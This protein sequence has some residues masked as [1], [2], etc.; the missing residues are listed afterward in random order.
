MKVAVQGCLHGDLD[1]I[2]ASVAHLEQH[3]NVRVDLVISC[4]DFQAIRNAGDLS[5]IA[6]PD[7]YKELKGFHRYYSGEK[8]APYP[9]LFI[10]GN[11]EASNYL[12]ELYYGGWVAPNIYYL[13]CSGVVRFGGLRIAGL[14]GI[15]DSRSYRLG[16]FE[17]PPY[18]RGSLRTV[19]HVREYEVRKL[20]HLKERSV[21]VF[22]SHDWPRGVA[23]CG[24]CNRARL[25]RSKPYFRQEV[26]R[27]ELGS[28]AAA[29]L[30]NR[31]KPGHWFSAHFHVKFPAVIHH[32][33]SIAEDTLTARQR[34]GTSD[35]PDGWMTPEVL[36]RLGRE[37]GQPSG[38]VTDQGQT[39]FLALDKCLPNRDFLQILD[40]PEAA[41]PKVLEHD[42]EWLAIVK[43]L[44]G[45][46]PME[47]RPAA[48]ATD[49]ASCPGPTAEEVRWVASRLEA[50]GGAAIKDSFC[51]T[52]PTQAEYEM[53][54]RQVGHHVRNPQTLALLELL[55]LPYQL[56]RNE[57]MGFGGGRG[58]QHRQRGNQQPHRGGGWQPGPPAHLVPSAV[59]LNQAVMAQ[60]Q[61]PE[62]IDIDIDVGV[63][64]GSEGPGAAPALV[65]VQVYLNSQAAAHD[66]GNPEEIDL[67]L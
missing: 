45:E 10:G 62:A 17:H 49:A 20:L 32:G 3:E 52:A 41:G 13:G 57:G 50:A 38:R 58:H 25:L 43:R 47:R 5:S 39:K 63:D 60:D 67:G 14:S 30:C 34:G 8:I 24:C 19:Y 37:G 31:I 65:P 40:F 28:P 29:R 46:M 64:V 59:Y 15:F 21:D 42:A 4:G 7:K 56:D 9:T 48:C 33:N 12:W 44:H 53:G 26:D 11:H 16:H 23:N 35:V 18:D 54:A 61:N 55:D 6:V 2:Y 27:D 36:E 66:Q 22:L 1:E 51:R